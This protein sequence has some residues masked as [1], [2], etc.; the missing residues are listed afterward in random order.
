MS[1][2]HEL[3]AVQGKGGDV[4]ILKGDERPEALRERGASRVP[5]VSALLREREGERGVASCRGE[6][7]EQSQVRR[8]EG[9]S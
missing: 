8:F 6:E 5:Y 9:L 4:P 3:V 7:A 1:L 2:L